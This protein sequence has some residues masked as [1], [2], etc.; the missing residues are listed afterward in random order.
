MVMT[1]AKTLSVDTPDDLARVVN[2][3]AKKEFVDQPGN[4]SGD[5]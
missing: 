5:A 3:M 1:N 4:V 2:L